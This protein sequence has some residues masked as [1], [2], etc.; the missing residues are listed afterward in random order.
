MSNEGFRNVPGVPEGWELVRV[1]VPDSEDWLIGYD[2]NPVAHCMLKRPLKL[3]KYAII[4]K[5]EQ[6]ARY[7]QF[8]NAEEFKPHRDRWIGRNWT[9]RTPAARGAYKPTAYNDRGIWTSVENF[10]TYEQMFDDGRCF[11]DNGTPFGVRIDE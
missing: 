10:E 11:D 6:P 4:R 5:I 1:G 7:R 9:D 3:A 8:A 2:G